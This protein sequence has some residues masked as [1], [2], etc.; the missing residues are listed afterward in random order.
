[1]IY[2]HKSGDLAEICASFFDAREEII[3]YNGRK[4]LVIERQVMQSRKIEEKPKDERYVFV[5]GFVKSYRQKTENPDLCL[6]EF[7]P[8]PESARAEI[9][10]LV[11]NIKPFA[12]RGP[13]TFSS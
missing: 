10:R 9:E 1:M 8:L 2:Q 5:L 7:E 12:F 11:R 3:E 6:S 13:L 4:V